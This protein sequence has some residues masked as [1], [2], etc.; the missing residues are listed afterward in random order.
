MSPARRLRFLALAVLLAA[1]APALAGPDLPRPVGPP[2][3]ATTTTVPVT[4]TTIDLA[5]MMAS[6]CPTQFCL[7][8]QIRE[9]ATWSSGVP[10]APEDFARTADLF[11]DPLVS[12]LSPGYDLIES[13]DI[14]D[15][16]RFRVVFSEPYGPWQQLFSRVI[17]PGPDPRDVTGLPTTGAF[18]FVEWVPGDRIVLRRD[19]EWWSQV[20]LISDA[21]A[22]NVDEIT[23]AFYPDLAE[24]L[25][26]LETGVVDVITTRPDLEAMERLRGMEAISHV[27]AP[28]P[29][30]EHIDFNHQDP[31]L[32]QG[33]VRR[34]ISLAIDRE[35]LLD[36]T[37]R[38]FDATTPGL[39]NTIWMANT[40][41][42]EDHYERGLDL[43]AAEDLL[44]ANG[45]APGGD[46]IYV[47]QGVRMSFR[48]ATTNDDPARVATFDSVR[49]DLAQIG[50]EVVAVFHSPSN[51]VTREVLF[52][53]PEA[54]QM[55]NFAWRLG[56]DPAR[57]N[58]SYHCGEFD[59]NVNRFCSPEVEELV[60]ATNSITDPA[61]RAM[62]YN[63]ADHLYLDRDAVIPLYQKPIL[64]AWGPGL[65]GPTPNWSHS[66]DMW[67]AAA[68]S[69]EESI[70]VALPAEPE[71]LD[72][73]LRGDEAANAV[74]SML[75]YGAL[76]MSPNHDYLPVLVSSVVVVEGPD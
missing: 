69:G 70:V 62:V 5:E 67:N 64:M 75:F 63:E 22:G 26:A 18:R 65:T 53:G 36:R 33:W 29:L 76:G 16:D 4:T 51:F 13:V 71:T 2:A 31:L 32:A 42:Y 43:A 34:A 37:V 59:L 47:C 50:I 56:P 30:W 19:P 35:K 45:C 39:D 40:S 6:E 44:V 46:G 68:W 9:G 27:V 7:V 24:M 38:L 66:T 52:G 8:Y 11:A 15:Q 61:E 10:V 23:F 72:P 60:R 73:L 48:W 12:S 14:I 54:W 20:D 55:I 58:E 57:Q 28:G 74:L 49:E 41:N 21:P 3:M 1:C 25:D 17:P